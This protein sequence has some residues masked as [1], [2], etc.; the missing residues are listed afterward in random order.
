MPHVREIIEH[1]LIQ[2]AVSDLI[3]DIWNDSQE[4]SNKLEDHFEK[5]SPVKTTAE[6]FLNQIQHCRQQIQKLSAIIMVHHDVMDENGFT[7]YLIKATE[8]QDEYYTCLHII[9]VLSSNS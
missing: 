6:F 2:N 7:S 5:S 9:D 8:A 3:D 4:L 1:G